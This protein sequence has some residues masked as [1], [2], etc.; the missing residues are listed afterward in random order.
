MIHA[1]FQA[2]IHKELDVVKVLLE[3]G[4]NINITDT[5]GRTPLIYAVNCSFTF[6]YHDTVKILIE[7]MSIEH[8]I[9]HLLYFIK[10]SCADDVKKIELIFST[11]DEINAE[12]K[13]EQLMQPIDIRTY[14]DKYGSTLE[15]IL[16]GISW[17]GNDEKKDKITKI[18]ETHFLKQ[19]ENN[20]KS[21]PVMF[22]QNSENNPSDQ[23][24][25]NKL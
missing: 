25:R 2:S 18:I 15:L 3:A 14:R 21:Q 13:G 5:L 12:R 11:I 23:T 1:V 17:D 10:A 19:K 22:L 6:S 24:T 7:K 9:G 16:Q 20:H 4:A 8:L